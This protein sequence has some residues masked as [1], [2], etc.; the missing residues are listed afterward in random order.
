MQCAKLL[1]MKFVDML[2][3]VA[4]ALHWYYHYKFVY[5]IWSVINIIRTAAAVAVV[6]SVF[7]PPFQSDEAPL[8][9]QIPKFQH[10]SHTANSEHT[11]LLTSSYSLFSLS[12]SSV[13]R[14]E[15]LTYCG[16]CWHC[17]GDFNFECNSLWVPVQIT[18]RSVVIAVCITFNA[19]LGSI[20]DH[21]HTHAKLSTDCHICTQHT[22]W[23]VIITNRR[24]DGFVGRSNTLPSL[25]ITSPTTS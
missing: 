16:T 13:T 8:L 9:V 23:T 14:S 11:V 6:C 15:M 10:E 22:R 19:H 4:L 1:V 18:M 3:C 12:V 25:Q 21:T 17:F 2:F 24:G 5:F 7:W 20:S